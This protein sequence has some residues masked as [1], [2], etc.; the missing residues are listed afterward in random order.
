MRLALTLLLAAVVALLTGHLAVVSF[1][2]SVI[3]SHYPTVV[4]RV[5]D[6]KSGAANQ[7]GAAR[8]DA[9]DGRPGIMRV[10]LTKGAVE[11]LA[12][13][14]VAVIEK[15]VQRTASIAGVVLAST[16]VPKSIAG[17]LQ[18]S[19][20]VVRAPLAGAADKPAPGEPATIIPLAQ[21]KPAARGGVT[22]GVT[23]QSARLIGIGSEDAAS[24]APSSAY[25]I[26]SGENQELQAGNHVIVQIPLVGN[27]AVR[28]IVPASAIIYDASGRTWVYAN[29][30]PQVFVREPVDI[31]VM[32]AETAILDKGPPAGA[33]VVKTGAF[34]LY[35]AE[36]AIG[37]DKVAH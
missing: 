8:L 11:R 5:Y 1:F 30:G 17:D 33:L 37:I 32:E 4:S 15:P 19:A 29:P 24:G 13:E 34:E 22:G 31:A 10:T 12:L 14:T 9:I 3:A 35:G 21:G 36:S 25:Y 7:E 16:A 28:K 20:L 26:L 18:S 2:P 23:G 6:S 27:G